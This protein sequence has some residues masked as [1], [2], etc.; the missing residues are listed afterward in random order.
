MAQVFTWGVSPSGVYKNNAMSRQLRYAS[1]CA[2]GAGLWAGA[3]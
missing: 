3:W 1:I 2:D